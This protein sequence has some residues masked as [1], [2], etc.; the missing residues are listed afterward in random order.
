VSITLGLDLGFVRHGL[1][2]DLAAAVFGLG[3]KAKL[4]TLK[5]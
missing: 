3:L 5:N 4:S 2:L 1:D